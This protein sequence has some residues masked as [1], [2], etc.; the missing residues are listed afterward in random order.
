MKLAHFSDWHFPSGYKRTAV[1]DFNDQLV[2]LRESLDQAA[3]LG[4]SHIVFTGDMVDRAD[5]Q[6]Y[7]HFL[8]AA[9]YAGFKGPDQVSL[10]PG[11][12]DIHPLSWEERALSMGDWLRGNYIG[13]ARAPVAQRTLNKWA[14]KT[15]RAAHRVLED[16]PFPFLKPLDQGRVILIGLDTVHEDTNPWKSARGRF[17]AEDL[18]ALRRAVRPRTNDQRPVLV[19]AMHHYPIPPVTFPLDIEDFLP[20][21][22]PLPGFL[23][24]GLE[25]IAEGLPIPGDFQEADLQ[26]LERL[27]GEFRFD[28]ILCGHTHGGRKV[29]RKWGARI[30]NSSSSSVA[31]HLIDTTAGTIRAFR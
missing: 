24:E 23:T 18:K 1:D 2:G 14:G 15:I 16:H 17:V 21:E 10:V 12:H 11:N 26:R 20:T 9:A 4:A 29:R 27:L 3:E 25:S 31:F 28:Y 6:D 13:S 30:V 22:V 19:L 8:N 5:S 7:R